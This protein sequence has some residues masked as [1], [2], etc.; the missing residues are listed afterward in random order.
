MGV[1]RLGVTPL[2]LNV[3]SFCQ[4]FMPFKTPQVR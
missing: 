1:L 2:D 4:P 3:I